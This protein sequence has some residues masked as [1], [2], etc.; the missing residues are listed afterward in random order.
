MSILQK[1][2]ETRDKLVQDE[3]NGIKITGER[4]KA[5]AVA[6]ILGGAKSKAWD[7]YMR[8]YAENPEQLA[9]LKLADD[10]SKVQDWMPEMAA[11]TVANATCGGG[12]GTGLAKNI[13]ERIDTDLPVAKADLPPPPPDDQV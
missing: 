4:L 3:K 11:Y 13:D 6:A 2:I 10:F 7:T 12:T 1:L 8:Q 9:R 5:L